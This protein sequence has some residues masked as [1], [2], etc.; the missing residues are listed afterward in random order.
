MRAA[1]QISA[2]E[3]ENKTVV[4]LKRTKPILDH[5]DIVQA[6]RLE[7]DRHQEILL[8]DNR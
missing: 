3:P 8:A 7:T 5:A 2:Q 4:I 1:K 6:E